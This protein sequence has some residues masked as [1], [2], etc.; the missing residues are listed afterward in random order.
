MKERLIGASATL[1]GHTVSHVAPE[2]FEAPLVQAWVK[3]DEGPE[4]FTLLFCTEKDAATLSSGQRLKLETTADE[5]RT[6]RWG[7]R[8]TFE[9]GKRDG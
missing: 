2:G 4:L 1:L 9:G 6:E 3:T 5:D 7:Y 8:P